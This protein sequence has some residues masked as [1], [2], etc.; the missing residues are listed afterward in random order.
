MEATAAPQ[1]PA[2]PE[3]AGLRRTLLGI[4][5][6]AVTRAQAVEIC[7]AAVRARR[8][9]EVG[10]VNVAK[11]VHLQ[12]DRALR[13]A[14]VGCGLIVA[15]GL[16]VV[17]AGTLLGQPLPERVTG[18]DLFLD[19]LAAAD[20]EQ[21]SVYLLGATQDVLE[22]VAGQIRTRFPRARIAGMRDGYFRA[23][24]EP[25]VADAIRRT[26]ADMLFV[27]ISTPKK[28]LF[29][30][31]YGAAMGVPVCHG[32]GGSFDVLAGKVQRAPERWQRLGIEWL[33][34]LLQEPRRMWKRYLTTNSAFLYLLAR[35]LLG[36]PKPLR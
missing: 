30:G 13:E 8:P 35:A 36:V 27:G 9:L 15:D 6:D 18:I 31:R 20:R 12:E 19:L 24:E 10:V 21:L 7:L 26:A 1:T 16:P 28:E 23:D 29:L 2:R 33:Y 17:W 32:V 25:A 3:A 11:L 4:P 5:V 22:G 34:R 14:I